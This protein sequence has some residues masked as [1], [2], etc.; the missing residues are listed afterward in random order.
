MKDNNAK[1]DKSKN[2]IEPPAKQETAPKIVANKL[3]K[4]IESNE[5]KPGQKLQPQSELAKAFKVGMSSIREAVNVLEV[6]GYLEV[7]HG[8]GTYVRNELPMNKTMMEKLEQDLLHASSYELFELRELIECHSVK[9]AAR[10]ADPLAV[11]R[12]KSAYEALRQSTGD[13]Q[14]FLECDL[15]FHL[16]I[17]KAI[18]LEATAAVIHLFFEIMHKQFELVSTTQTSGYREKAVLSAEQIVSSIMKGDD[19]LAVRCMRRHLDSAKHA[20]A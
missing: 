14:S 9:Q 8:S 10:R 5:L 18:D 20:I 12:I 16:T 11:D 7:I 13:R 17:S 6:M 1:T 19:A 4:K 2:G 15:N 3:I